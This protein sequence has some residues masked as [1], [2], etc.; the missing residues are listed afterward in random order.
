M[1]TMKKQPD[2]LKMFNMDRFQALWAVSPDEANEYRAECD[3]Y[4]QEYIK[5]NNPNFKQPEVQEYKEPVKDKLPEIV[6]E[7]QQK[8]VMVQIL[9]D[10]GMKLAS[11]KWSLQTLTKKV[12]ELNK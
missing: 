6:S 9:K 2:D 12:A 1:I 5:E 7:D 4:W 3:A 8:E 10:S 11:T